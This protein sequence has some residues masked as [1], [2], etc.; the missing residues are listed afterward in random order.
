MISINKKLQLQ[1]K[2]YKISVRNFFLNRLKNRYYITYLKM[3]IPNLIFTCVVRVRFVK[4]L[5]ESLK[6]LLR[7]FWSLDFDRNTEKQAENNADCRKNRPRIHV[8]V[9]WLRCVCQQ[10]RWRLDLEISLINC[11]KLIEALPKILNN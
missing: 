3:L 6:Q 7:M 2:R 10:Q 8:F 1:H 5:D 4:F 11:E 9:K